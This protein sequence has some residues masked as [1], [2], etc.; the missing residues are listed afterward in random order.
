L[1]AWKKAEQMG[2]QLYDAKGRPSG[3]S[4]STQSPGGGVAGIVDKDGHFILFR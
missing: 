3:L 1:V 2:W 4:S